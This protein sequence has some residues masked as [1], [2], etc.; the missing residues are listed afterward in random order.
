MGFLSKSILGRML[1][2]HTGFADKLGLPGADKL[3]TSMP[4]VF[5]DSRGKGAAGLG[6]AD[7][8]SGIGAQLLEG[9][10]GED[11]VGPLPTD[12]LVVD[13]GAD[14]SSPAPTP[15]AP[16][17][18]RDIV[19]RWAEQR[20]GGQADLGT[21]QAARAEAMAALAGLP[22]AGM[23]AGM[24]G[25]R[26]R[27]GPPAVAEPVTDAELATKP[28]AISRMPNRPMLKPGMV[29]PD[30]LRRRQG[31]DDRMRNLIGAISSAR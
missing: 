25:G 9:R 10:A 30:L 12:P 26:G 22:Q 31:V 6:G 3:S 24:G 7:Y 23:G 17:T 13:S 21:R 11:Q 2:R 19:R 5:R 1:K 27:G 4:S 14:T 16:L 20:Q 8:N 15:A 29:N 18:R 28:A